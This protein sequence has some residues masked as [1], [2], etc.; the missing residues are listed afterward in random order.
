MAKALEERRE[1]ARDINGEE[2]FRGVIARIQA[3]LADVSGTLFFVV[4]D[5][6]E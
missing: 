1:R 3:S 2:S 6:V 4:D 5:G